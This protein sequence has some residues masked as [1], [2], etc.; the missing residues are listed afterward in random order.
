[1]DESVSIALLVAMEQL[2]A[3]QRVS[4]ILHDVFQIPFN[5]IS[6]I[7]GRSPEACRQLATTGRRNVRSSRRP[8]VH[9]GSRDQ[10]IVAFAQACLDG[11]VKSLAAVLDPDVV[12]RAD[13]GESVSA[14]RLPLRGARSVGRYLLGVLNLE[15]RRR[16]DFEVTLGLVNGYTGIV[17]RR[18]KRVL[19]VLDLEVIDGTVGAIALIANPEKLKG[20]PVHAGHHR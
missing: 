11:D 13:G 3:P 9:G 2:T 7:V 20:D 15:Q 17:I 19:W 14:A 10:V 18:N 5:E 1:L 8:E 4:L 12:S 16:G 6:E